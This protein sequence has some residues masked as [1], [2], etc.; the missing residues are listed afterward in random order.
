MCCFWTHSA[1]FLILHK[2]WIHFSRG[3]IQG[4]GATV[5]DLEILWCF[6]SS[7]FLERANCGQT[8]SVNLKR[9]S[10][11]GLSD[12]GIAAIAVS[13]IGGSWAALNAITTVISAVGEVSS[14]MGVEQKR[15]QPTIRDLSSISETSLEHIIVSV[16]R[17]S[18][19]KLLH[20]Q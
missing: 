7:K 10:G 9:T 3:Y 17:I 19:L 16:I 15:F 1:N 11:F 5:R 18:L 6:Y 14:D 20:L 13:N 8:I 12:L 4:F 2:L